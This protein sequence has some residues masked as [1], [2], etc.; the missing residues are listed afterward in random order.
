MNLKK[1]LRLIWI[2]LTYSENETIFE[3]LDRI[4]DYIRGYQDALDAVKHKQKCP[5]PCG[6]EALR[7]IIYKDAAYLAKALDPDE[8]LSQN[9]RETAIR[10][11]N[12]LIDIIRVILDNEVI[13][14]KYNEQICKQCS[15]PTM[16]LGELCYSCTQKKLQE[17]GLK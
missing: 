11:N 13:E 15:E 9:A 2:A 5:Y 3:Q 1:R 4:D 10:M 6:W 17:C 16:H 14:P 12:Y 7:G 8:P